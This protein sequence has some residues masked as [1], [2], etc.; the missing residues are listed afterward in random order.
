MSD[1]RALHRLHVST[2]DLLIGPR[3]WTTNLFEAEK[4][5]VVAILFSR[6]GKTSSRSICQHLSH[7]LLAEVSCSLKM[8]SNERFVLQ[9]LSMLFFCPLFAPETLSF[10]DVQDAS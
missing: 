9:A 4:V 7:S 1:D 5:H 6:G 10:L 2:A 8:L 3:F